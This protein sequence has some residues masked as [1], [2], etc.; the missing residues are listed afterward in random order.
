MLVREAEGKGV[1]L[2]VS[3]V[4][5]EGMS[6][7]LANAIVLE[8]AIGLIAKQEWGAPGLAESDV[9]EIENAK[10][11]LVERLKENLRYAKS[12]CENY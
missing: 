10:V 5:I 7:Q 1:Q 11:R 4:R 8:I 12:Q 3:A 6:P 2:S 9:R